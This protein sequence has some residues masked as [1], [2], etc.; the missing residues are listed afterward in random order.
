MID[1]RKLRG[2]D[3]ATDTSRRALI[4]GIAGQDGSYLA[5][6]LLADGYSV[7][8]LVK[9]DPETPRPHL[10]AIEDQITLDSVDLNDSSA[11][12]ELIAEIAADEIYNLAA[13]SV[14]GASWSR[15]S[16]TLAFL[17]G[18]VASLLEAIRIERPSAR[19]FQAT[20]SEIFRNTDQVPQSEATTPRPISPYGVGK[21][22][23]HGLVEAY[24]RHYGLHAS[25]GI[26][27]NHESPRRPVDFVPSKIVDAAVRIKLGLQSELTLGDRTAR[28]DWGYA[29]EYAEAM[30]AIV[31][32]H[33]PGDYIVATGET[34]SVDELVNLAFAAVDLDPAEYV[35]TDPSFLRGEDEAQL[36]GDPSHIAKTVG[37]SAQTSFEELVKL[38]VE[39]RMREFQTE[40]QPG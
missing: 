15:P 5:E 11:T 38:M 39:S 3:R 14:V 19:F 25:S 28:R 36:V 24:R 31:G 22:A 9:N 2:I 16:E 29:P 34:H 33:T 20:S 13:P 18:S 12:C 40:A 7:F 30:R 10:S 17:T 4:T 26:L 6:S 1:A 21:L 27:Y 37:W 35:T 32:H 23:G 8:G